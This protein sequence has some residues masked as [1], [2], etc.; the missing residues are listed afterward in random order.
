MLRQGPAVNQ[1]VIKL[2]KTII[3]C[4]RQF[5][6]KLSH[7][8]GPV[9]VRPGIFFGTF[10]VIELRKN[11]AITLRFRQPMHVFVF[12]PSNRLNYINRSSS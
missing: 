5:P 4:I 2:Q 1:G 8:V 11:V 10:N 12:M 9:G 7:Y 6:G 3:D